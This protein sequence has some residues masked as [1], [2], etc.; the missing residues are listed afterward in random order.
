MKSVRLVAPGDLRTYTEP[1]PVPEKGEALVR[2]KA[3]GICGSDLHWFSEGGIGSAQLVQPL[4]PGH[5]MA[6]VTESGQAVAIDPAIPCRICE[7]CLRGDPNL[8]PSVIFA[9]HDRQDGGLREWMAWEERNLYPLPEGMSFAEGAMLEPLGVA[10]HALDLAKIRIGM[11]I[12]VFGCGPIGL[13]IVQL[14]RNAGAK[15]IIATDVLAHRVDAARSFGADFAFDVSQDSRLDQILTASSGRG[16][17]V[18]FEAAG[19]QRAV[20]TAI[21]AAIPGGRVILVGVPHPDQTSFRA[22]TARFKGL[23]LKLVRRM[24][25]TYPRAIALAAEKKVDLNS[26]VSHRFP[27][28]QAGEAFRVAVR[29]EGLKVIIE[30]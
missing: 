18:A 15:A 24:K 27:L 14:A 1:A 29:R 10:I 16:V 21:A 11:T 20:E 25:L 9:G 7:F 19:D 4:V 17:D 3:V 23:T 22:S 5:E 26:L 2:V 8:C 30:I 6:G 12:G 13:M 28:E